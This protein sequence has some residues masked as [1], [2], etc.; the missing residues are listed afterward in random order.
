MQ[1]GFNWL[2]GVLF[3]HPAIALRSEVLQKAITAASTPA[4]PGAGGMPSE[5]EAA[6]N[7]APRGRSNGMDDPEQRW[8]EIENNPQLVVGR[9]RPVGVRSRLRLGRTGDCYSG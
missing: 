7:A 4:Q 2:N 1:L 8:P 6:S 3:K 5:R 9:S